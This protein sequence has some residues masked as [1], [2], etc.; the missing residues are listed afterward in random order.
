MSTK[1]PADQPFLRK[2]DS[3]NGT[4][5]ASLTPHRCRG[6]VNE[7]SL[8]EQKSGNKTQQTWPIRLCHHYAVIENLAQ[9][10]VDKRTKIHFCWLLKKS[11]AMGSFLSWLKLAMLIHQFYASKQAHWPTRLPYHLASKRMAHWAFF[12]G[13]ADLSWHES[14]I[15][16]QIRVFLINIT[17][18]RQTVIP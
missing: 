5:V 11:C 4:R 9:T 17:S 8:N 3:R 14:L 12:V 1:I 7:V 6:N 15:C 16:P 18:Y 2:T 13:K 10:V